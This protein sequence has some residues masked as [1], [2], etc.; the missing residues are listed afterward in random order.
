MPIAVVAVVA[1]V[2]NVAGDVPDAAAVDEAAGSE[3]DAADKE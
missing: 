2:G 1:F 3:A